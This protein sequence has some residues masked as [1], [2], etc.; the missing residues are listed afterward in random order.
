MMQN[1]L[2]LGGGVM[3]NMLLSLLTTPIITR[4]VSPES[5]GVYSLFMLYGS[6]ALIVA[7]GGMDQTLLR[8]F[9][10]SDSVAYRSP[11]LHYCLKIAF[12]ILGVGG[13]VILLLNSL[14]RFEFASLKASCAFLFYLVLLVVNRFSS[15]V[16]RLSHDSKLY[17]K[18]LIL[19]KFIFALSA[20]TLLLLFHGNNSSEILII[21]L[22][23]STAIV[24]FMQIMS[25]REIWFWR[26][27]AAEQIPRQSHL[28]RYGAPYIVS[29]LL[30]VLLT[31][32]ARII[33]GFECGDAEVGIFSAGISLT[34]AFSIIQSTF[35]T[36]WMPVAVEHHANCPGD[37]SLFVLA[38]HGITLMM[39]AA[40]FAFILAKDV[41]VLLLGSE[42][43]SVAFLLPL[44]CFEPIFYT[45]SETTVNG[46]VLSEKSHYHIWVSV[47][48]VFLNLT[49]CLIGIPAFGMTGAAAATAAGYLSFYI[50]RCWF[51]HRAMPIPYQYKKAVVAVGLFVIFALWNTYSAFNGYMV[52]YALLSIAIIAR[53][54]QDFVQLVWRQIKA[55]R[56]SVQ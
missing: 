20:I 14:A 11:L 46:I 36:L 37:N 7:S 56:R 15:I 35:N 49:I 48:A 44:L 2:I 27:D 5:Y 8:Y 26:G 40:G 10:N 42:Y 47:C 1:I 33:L 4:L 50:A 43:R 21:S 51:S 38:N 32:S 18:T 6:V 9:Y 23:T 55:R 24:T 34:A 41:L 52:V 16:V 39:I 22:V 53:L 28:I 19:N 17:S 30:S 31:A 54:Y 12:I 29:G 25:K 13:V 45:M 3:G